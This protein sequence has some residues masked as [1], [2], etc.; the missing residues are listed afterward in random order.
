LKKKGNN[1]KT[2]GFDPLEGSLEKGTRKPEIHER[3]IKETDSLIDQAKKMHLKEF[4]E[5]IKKNDIKLYII[6]APLPN[7][8]NQYSSDRNIEQLAYRYKVQYWNFSQDTAFLEKYQLFHDETHLNIT[9]ARIF[10]G[11]VA[12]RIDKD[13]NEQK[14]R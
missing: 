13:V 3:P 14:Y 12:S 11:I 9:G 5:E 8:S 4:I 2:L 10:S 1:I 6:E 7:K